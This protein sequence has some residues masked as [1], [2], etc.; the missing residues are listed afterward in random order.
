MPRIKIHRSVTKKKFI[1]NI[2]SFNFFSHQQ[3]KHFQMKEKYGCYQEERERE[4]E[5]ESMNVDLFTL[6]FIINP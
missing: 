1:F 4:R 6:V 5:R 3:K 2:S